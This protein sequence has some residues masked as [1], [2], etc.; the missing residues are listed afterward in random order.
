MLRRIYSV[1]YKIIKCILKV[2]FY[3]YPHDTKG[4]PEEQLVVLS[5]FYRMW[6]EDFP[7]V[8]IPEVGGTICVCCMPD[9]ISNYTC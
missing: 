8:V 5:S 7:N 2:Y 9:A 1:Q 3:P 6:H 4:I